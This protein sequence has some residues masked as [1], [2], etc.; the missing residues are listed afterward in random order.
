MSKINIPTTPDELKEFMNDSR[1]VQEVMKNGQFNEV[2]E[3]YAKNAQ[4]KDAALGEQ[5]REQ[6]Q[7]ELANYLKAQ[8]QDVDR[9]DVSNLSAGNALYNKAAAGAKVE[10]YSD[11]ADYFKTIWHNTYQSDQVRARVQKLRA[12]ASTTDPA[13]GGFLV[14][15]SLRSELQ[16]VS[17]ENSVVRPRARVIPMETSRVGFPA[18]DSTSNVSSVHGGIVGYWKAEAASLEESNASFSEIVLDASKLTTYTTVN[19]ELL[20]DSGIS[21]NAFVN[22]AFPEALAYYEDD[23]FLNGNG[24]GQPLGVYNA[25]GA[26]AVSRGTTSEVNFADVVNMYVRMLPSSINRAVWVVSPAV[27]AQLLQ[28]TMSGSDSALWLNNQQAINGP[29]FTLMGRPVIVTEKA[30]NLGSAGDIAF[31]DFGMYLIGDRQVMTASSSPHYKFQTDQTAFKITTRV[32]G[33]PWLQSAITPKN[34]GS[35]LSPYVKLAA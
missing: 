4:K 9:I 19:N 29:V 34:N 35:T 5:V 30:P 16:R 15:E 27:V 24:V 14:P 28:M 22:Q 26:I 33:R 8:G 10:E 13:G 7:Q 11:A 20:S 2:V 18:V 32:D 1:N 25:P 3:A 31:I 17:L 21:F 12:A 6:V 23:A